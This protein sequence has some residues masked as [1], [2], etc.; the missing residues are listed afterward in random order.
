ME[1]V[2]EVCCN[3]G[4]KHVEKVVFDKND[5]CTGEKL[6]KLTNRIKEYIEETK[7]QTLDD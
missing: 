7:Q 5:E 1:L 4:S 2:V 3:D 6:E